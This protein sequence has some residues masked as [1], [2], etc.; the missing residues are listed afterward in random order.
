MSHKDLLKNYLAMK[1]ILV[2]TIL[3]LAIS[4]SVDAQT[5][6]AINKDGSAPDASSLLDVS[7]TDGGVLIPRMTAVQRVAISNPATGLVVYDTDSTRFYYYD[8]GWNTIAN[9]HQLGDS[10]IFTVY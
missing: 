4:F 1:I 5:G 2:Q 6:V 3:I 7:G 10:N 8:A 9:P